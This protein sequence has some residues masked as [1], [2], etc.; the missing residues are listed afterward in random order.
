[1]VRTVVVMSGTAS[2]RMV[3]FRTPIAKASNAM[4]V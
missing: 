3:E 1:M 2:L 4:I